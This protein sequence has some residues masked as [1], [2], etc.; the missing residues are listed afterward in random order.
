MTSKNK[1]EK[2]NWIKL[3]RPTPRD[4]KSSQRNEHAK[5]G[6][7]YD[8]SIRQ[9]LNIE[10]NKDYICFINMVAVVIGIYFLYTAELSVLQIFGL[11]L[12]VILNTASFWTMLDLIYEEKYRK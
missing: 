12:F 6:A 8:H 5:R 9:R 10:A 11:V 2:L 1:H 3:R 4:C 7:F